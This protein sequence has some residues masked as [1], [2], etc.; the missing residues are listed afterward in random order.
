MV[1]A[2]ILCIGIWMISYCS[3][4]EEDII[5]KISIACQIADRRQ[6]LEGHHQ[7]KVHNN[8]MQHI[9][10][11]CTRALDTSRRFLSVTGSRKSYMGNSLKYLFGNV[12]P[13]LKFKFQNARPRSYQVQTFSNNF[14][15]KKWVDFGLVAVQIR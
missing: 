9:C 3:E 1:E 15:V 7:K 13:S 14:H 2:Y 11:I 4:N 8:I 5:I 12:K 10:W 6:Q